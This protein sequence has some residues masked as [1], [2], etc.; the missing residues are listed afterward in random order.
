MILSSIILIIISLMYLYVIMFCLSHL[1]AVT[2]I[3]YSFFLLYKR[4]KLL[5]STPPPDFWMLLSVFSFWLLKVGSLCKRSMQ[6]QFHSVRLKES[7]GEE[8]IML[9]LN[10]WQFIIMLSLPSA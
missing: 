5:S 8:Y 2:L 10:P 7:R 6:L 9:Q 4:L 3:N 1:A